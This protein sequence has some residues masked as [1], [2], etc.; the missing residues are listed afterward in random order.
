MERERADNKLFIG[1][2]SRTATEEEVRAL[3]A[4]FGAVEKVYIIKE[5]ATGQSRGCA[6][7]KFSTREGATA[8]IENLHQKMT[9]PGAPQ[10][11]VAK[12]ADPP[13]PKAPAG[14]MGRRGGV[15]GAQ[16]GEP[17][18]CVQSEGTIQNAVPFFR[19]SARQMMPPAVASS[20]GSM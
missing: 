14:A 13:K 19:T 12:W 18:D 2:L 20:P 11:L 10:P 9:M 3:V 6:F 1:M 5:K 8:V 7:V 17:W 16:G 4:P 15:G